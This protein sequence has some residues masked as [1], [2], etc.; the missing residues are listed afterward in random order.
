MM[1]A[2]DE[3]DDPAQAYPIYS[4][5]GTI[6]TP[7]AMNKDGTPRKL[8]WQSYANLENALSVL[9]DGSDANISLRVGQGHKVRSFFNNLNVPM[10]P[11]SVTVDTHN[12]GGALFRPMGGNAPEVKFVMGGPGSAATGISGAH[13]VYRDAVVRA[14]EAQ[15]LRP[16]AAQSIS[17]ETIKGLCSHAQS[18]VCR[19]GARCGG[20]QPR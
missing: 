6:A 15:G 17:W 5:E 10:D 18:E 14:A 8:V 19:T 3:L 2:A 4:P 20:L 13:G 16:S 11:R 9:H 7:V 1:R 12:V